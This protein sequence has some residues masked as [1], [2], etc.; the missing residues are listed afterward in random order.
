MRRGHID[1]VGAGACNRDQFE[2]GGASQQLARQL[3]P[4]QQNDVRIVHARG[5]SCIVRVA[6]LEIAGGRTQRRRVEIAVRNGVVIQKYRFHE[7]FTCLTRESRI[8]GR[9]PGQS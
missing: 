2:P 4:I 1:V 8:I 3:G 9:M 6:Q 7:R 5:N